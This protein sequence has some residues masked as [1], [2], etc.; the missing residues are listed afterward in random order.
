VR[1]RR[2]KEGIGRVSSTT[3]GPRWKAHFKAF[4]FLSYASV[5]RF[6]LPS[7]LS[8][9]SPPPP[10]PPLIQHPSRLSDS[11]QFPDK[12]IHHLIPIHPSICPLSPSSI[13]AFQTS[14][15][16]SAHPV[17]RTARTTIRPSIRGAGACAGI[18]GIATSICVSC[19]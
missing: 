15:S 7:S 3:G 19:M 11:D 13:A 16:R 2:K 4:P 17:T 1:E 6:A 10:P 9:S 12:R 18:V 14:N 8:L 5:A